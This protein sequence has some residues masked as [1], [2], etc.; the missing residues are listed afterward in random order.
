[1]DSFGKKLH[2]LATV[3][4]SIVQRNI[5]V[6]LYI[7]WCW[8]MS[9]KHIDPDIERLRKE[10]EELRE[11]YEK[12]RKEKE[13]IEKE[14][15]AYK[16]AHP[17]TVGVKHGKPYIIKLPNLPKIRNKPG[18]RP[19]HKPAFRR[20]PEFIKS[21]QTID[22]DAC[23]KCDGHNL[24]E[25]QEEQERTV[26]DIV[27]VRPIA[28]RQIII[29]RY[30]RDCKCLVS[31]KG[32]L[33]LPKARFSL[34]IMLIVTYLKI[35]L[36]LPRHSIP[37]LMNSLFGLK[38]SD[39]EV[40]RILSQV[41][42]AFGP[43]YDQL[44][45]DIRNAPARHMDETS[46]RIDGTTAWLWAFV[47]KGEVLYKIASS[48]GHEVPLKVLGKHP[49][50]VDIHDRFSAYNTL[51]RV[52]GKRPQQVC[53]AHLIQDCKELAQFYGEEGKLIQRVM[54]K[55]YVR[56]CAFDHKGTDE[57]IDDLYCAMMNDIDRQYKSSHCNK[58]VKGLKK[59]QESLF[60]FVKNPDVEGTNNRAERALR[61]SVVARKISGGS[62]SEFGASVYETLL[63]VVHTIQLRGQ[64]IIEHGP[65]I[66]LTSHG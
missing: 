14:F 11:E 27:L 21:V 18:A 16:M 43:F 55:T 7:L 47:T 33:A 65:D 28:I 15:K 13:R 53:W 10:I 32:M 23:P 51:A 9:K 52:T 60:Q 39:G 5:S 40:S 66:L 3:L 1:L 25:M 42:N 30:C 34:R 46:W 38:M 36:R 19:G 37:Q 56:A 4:K 58:F 50:G 41:A 22:I 20:M 24:S 17:E 57:D 26:E 48:R 29:R 54:K 8:K 59:A 62:R 2:P 12:L 49:K 6:R 64:N 45:E 61:H 44:V 35:G 63:S 31:G